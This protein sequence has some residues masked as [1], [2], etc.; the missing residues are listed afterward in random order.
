MFPPSPQRPAELLPRHV[1]HDARV[2]S[3]LD[4]SASPP[5]PRSGVAIG[6]YGLPSPVSPLRTQYFDEFAAAAI[7]PHLRPSALAVTLS[8]PLPLAE[9]RDPFELRPD[10]PCATLPSPPGSAG[11]WPASAQG[12]KNV[13]DIAAPLPQSRPA[14]PPSPKLAL[15]P[16]SFTPPWTG[17]DRPVSPALVSSGLAAFQDGLESLEHGGLRIFLDPAHCETKVP[18]STSDQLQSTAETSLSD[19]RAGTLP[20]SPSVIPECGWA[21]LERSVQVIGNPSCGGQ[22]NFLPLA[23]SR[24]ADARPPENVTTFIWKLFRLLDRDAYAPCIQW[25]ESGRNILIALS[26]VRFLSILGLFFRH[27]SVKSFVRQLHIYGFRR[28]PVSRLPALVRDAGLESKPHS[29]QPIRADTYA[30]FH[31]RD[32]VRVDSPHRQQEMLAH[33]RPGGGQAS[34]PPASTLRN[35]RS[36]TARSDP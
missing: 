10:F 29:E 5:S 35:T 24:T 19:C 21:R 11:G 32:F 25:D 9:L 27:G 30:A 14:E 16:H 6:M 36:R 34:R 1:F 2:L 7:N 20:S 23:S 26:H 15:H 3:R 4:M 22:Q 31:H 28:V 18:P 8:P 17:M 33:M 13:G 12:S